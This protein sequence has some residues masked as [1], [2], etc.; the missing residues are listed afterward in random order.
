M[1]FTAVI[2][3]FGEVL[4]KK[5]I[6]STKKDEEEYLPPA[7]VKLVAA[8]QRFID[9]IDAEDDFKQTLFRGSHGSIV[10]Q[11]IDAE[12]SLVSI[13]GSQ[14]K[15]GLVFLDMRLTTKEILKIMGAGG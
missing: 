7:L 6:D 8:T 13:V 10:L 15:L 12:L 1:A 5:W 2:S 9:E 3:K 4:S 14:V 11:P